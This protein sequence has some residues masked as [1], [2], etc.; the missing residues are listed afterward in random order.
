MNAPRFGLFALVPL[1]VA[2]RC[3]GDD[4]GPGDTD[5]S[6]DWSAA[7][8]LT[9]AVHGTIGSILTV[10]WEQLET[11]SGVV[12][13]HIDDEETWSS[14]P[15]KEWEAGA[16]EQLILG[17]PFTAEVELRLEQDCARGAY[18][19]RSVSAQTDPLPDGLPHAALV[20]A[21]DGAWDPSWPYIL[22]SIDSRNDHSDPDQTWTVILNRAGR[23]VWA[24]PTQAF[25]ITMAP[26]VAADGASLLLDQNSFWYIFD[27][28]AASQVLR[29]DLLGNEIELFDTPGLHHPFTELPDGTI[30]WG[31]ADGMTETIELLDPSTLEQR[32]LW[33]C[34][35]FHQQIGA[36]Q[37]CSANTLNWSQPRDSYLISFFSTDSVVEVDA[38]SG[39]SLRWFGHLPGSYAFDPEDSAFYWQHGTN[40]TDAGTLLLSTLNGEPGDETHAREY[41]L[42]DDAQILRQVWAFGEGEGIYGYEMGEA[43]RLPNGNTMHNMGTAQRL[44]EI[45]PTGDVVWDLSWSRGSYIG[46]S[47]G[48]EDL[49]GLVE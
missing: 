19:T 16:Q 48:I 39:E 45:T 20:S 23:T 15:A 32:T 25:R 4:T 22:V 9:V 6:P 26:R 7:S 44:R 3:S 43:W 2:A 8:G 47:V 5:T 21:V 24:L 14:S 49:Y 38:T 12:A 11:C 31:A 41:E 28:G 18:S 36:I 17:V 40:F 13:Y 1:L 29:V 37:P 46:R 10:G 42:D 34:Y 27:A 35:G 30:A 33:S